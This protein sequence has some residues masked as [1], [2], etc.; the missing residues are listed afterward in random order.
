[1]EKKSALS[2]NWYK[3]QSAARDWSDRFLTEGIITF[4]TGDKLEE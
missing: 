4:E 2:R 1:M 3:I